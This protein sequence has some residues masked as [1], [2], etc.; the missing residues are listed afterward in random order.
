MYIMNHNPTSSTMILN[1]TVLF[2]SNLA[3]FRVLLKR[4][5]ARWHLPRK[6]NAVMLS[7]PSPSCSMDR[8]FWKKLV[9]CLFCF[10]LLRLVCPG[11]IPLGRPEKKSAYADLQVCNRCVTT[12]SKIKVCSTKQLLAAL[13]TPRNMWT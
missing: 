5:W 10:A 6:E 7:G 8:W 9:G 3:P 4:H 13:Q 2:P 12:F 11:L 1:I